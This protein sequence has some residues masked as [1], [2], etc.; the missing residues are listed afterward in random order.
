MK[1]ISILLLLS[2]SLQLF[3]HGDHAKPVAK[4]ASKCTKEE[5]EKAVPAAIGALILGG[6][7]DKE[8]SKMT[9][10]K[11]EL[12]TFSKGPEWT[13]TV[14]DKTQKDVKRQRLYVFITTDGFLNG[15]NYTGN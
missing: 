7:I 13:A 6:A 2:F 11:V 10:E 5:V 15:S 12:K 14:F 3:A 1:T 4:C 9:I 8:W